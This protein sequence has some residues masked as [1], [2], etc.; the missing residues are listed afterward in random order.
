MKQVLLELYLSLDGLDLLAVV[1]LKRGNLHR[2]HF[3]CQFMGGLLDL[4]K[5]ALSDGLLLLSIWFT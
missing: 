5:S 3:S 1:L 4:A 2:H